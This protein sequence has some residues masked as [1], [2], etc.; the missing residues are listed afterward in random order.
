MLRA[1]SCGRNQIRGVALP[2]SSFAASLQSLHKQPEAASVPGL[3]AV[4]S[5]DDFQRIARKRL[6]KSIYEYLASGSDDEQ[7]LREDRV[8]FRRLALRP[9]ALRPIGGLSCAVPDFCGTGISLALPVFASPAGVH[10]VAHAAGECATARA[11]ASAGTAF[12]LSQHAT[13]SIEEVAIT[14]PE[15]H[16]WYQ[17]YILRD[18][19]RSEALLRRAVRAGSRGV[20]LTID[21][22]RFGFRE[23]D[24]R[25]G[26]RGLPQGLTLANYV[27]AA[28]VPQGAWASGEHDSWDQNT[29]A[30]FDDD[31]SWDDVGWVRQVIDQ[32]AEEMGARRIPLVLK[33]VLTA[34]D[35]KATV[36][37]GADGVMVSTH[38]GRQLDSTLGAIDALPEVVEAVRE[39]E[40]DPAKFAVLL[41]SGVR[42]GTD[43]VKALALGAQAV[44]VGKP[45]FFALAVGGEEGV[46][47][48]FQ[49]LR[50]ETETAMALCGARTVADIHPGLVERR[51]GC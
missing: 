50:V 7:T 39:V 34:E 9:R 5:V 45:L 29:E 51:E 44:G 28:A 46:A 1:L 27:D 21:S 30:I 4:Y 35:A 2:A 37:A 20:Y 49:I 32:A 40:P 48:L 3:A 13:K 36:E 8:G 33:G 16:R 10:A 15:A 26:F 31:A 24:A 43:V 6:S 22:V 47:K 23:A 19:K 41:D 17:A 12:G 25:N 18:R 14:A 11:C 38:G 42:R